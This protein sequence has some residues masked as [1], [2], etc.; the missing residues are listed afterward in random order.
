[1]LF[2]NPSLVPTHLESRQSTVL[3][4]NTY[5]NTFRDEER[6]A[7]RVSKSVATKA[8]RKEWTEVNLR[9]GI[10]YPM[11]ANMRSIA[12]ALMEMGF[13][14]YAAVAMLPSSLLF[15]S[16]LIILAF[17]TPVV[18]YYIELRRRPRSATVTDEGITFHYKVGRNQSATWDD[19]KY[20]QLVE[21]DRPMGR[22]TRHMGWMKATTMKLP[23][24]LSYEAANAAMTAYK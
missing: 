11:P 13:F 16:L 17:S 21:Y 1:M 9:G 14:N 20:L 7:H 19:I 22:G 2:G 15:A 6:M 12:F 5:F 8:A 23:I 10:T 3:L 4:P 18:M 24:N